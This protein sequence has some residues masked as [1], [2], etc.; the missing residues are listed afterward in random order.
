MNDQKNEKDTYL[1]GFIERTDILR[2]RPQKND[3][4]KPRVSNFSSFAFCSNER[5]KVLKQAFL[6]LYS[7]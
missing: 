2:R 3:E 1:I 4:I 5:V 7:A 6:R